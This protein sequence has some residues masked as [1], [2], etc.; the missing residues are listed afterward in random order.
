MLSLLATISNLYVHYISRPLSIWH[1]TIFYFAFGCCEKYSTTLSTEEYESA[2]PAGKGTQNSFSSFPTN[3]SFRM[4][5]NPKSV[6]KEAFSA[7]VE[8]GGAFRKEETTPKTRH[9]TSG[10]ERNPTWGIVA[11]VRTERNILG[12][13]M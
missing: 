5:S 13:L 7:M 3:S 10:L 2:F 1:L 9:N 6:V 11:I 4:Q 12:V 8:V